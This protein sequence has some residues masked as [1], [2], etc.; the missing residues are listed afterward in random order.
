MPILK[1]IVVPVCG[2]VCG[3]D[4]RLAVEFPFS[5]TASGA[6]RLEQSMWNLSTSPMSTIIMNLEEILGKWANFFQ[7]KMSNTNALNEYH[8]SSP[9]SR[10]VVCSHL[11]ISQFLQDKKREL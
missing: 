9:Q 6:V 5:V 8:V 4:G 7:Y 10:R 11:F 1:Q 2:G 3:G